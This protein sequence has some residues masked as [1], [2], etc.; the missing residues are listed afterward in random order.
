[1]KKD[2]SPLEKMTAIAIRTAG[3]ALEN[4][5]ALIRVPPEVILY[6]DNAAAVRRKPRARA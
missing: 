3:L 5:D 4:G 6:L 2:T 1:M